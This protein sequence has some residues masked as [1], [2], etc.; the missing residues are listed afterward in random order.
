MYVYPSITIFVPIYWFKR[1]LIN[2]ENKTA[3]VKPPNGIFKYIV[4][5]YSSLL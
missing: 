4:I 3:F 1:K 5:V 2:T